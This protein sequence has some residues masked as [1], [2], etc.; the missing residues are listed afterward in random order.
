[1]SYRYLIVIILLF[2]LTACSVP[3]SIQGTPE[4]LRDTQANTSQASPVVE[5]TQPK[6]SRTT[7][8]KETPSYQNAVDKVSP[9]GSGSETQK[10]KDNKPLQ[11]NVESLP[12]PAFINEV[13]GN[14][15]GMSFEVEAS[16]QT[17][18][19][20][21]TLRVSEPQ[22]P[23]QLYQVA[24]Q[25]LDNYGVTGVKQGDILRFVP[26]TAAPEGG[27]PPILISGR[28]LPDVP[29]S[30]R[31]VFQIVPLR[32]VRN[33][34][35]AGW[36]R[37]LYP[38]KKLQISEDPERNAII[39]SG[40]PDLVRNAAEAVAFLDQPNMRGR[41]SLRIEPVF[42]SADELSTQLVSVLNT[43]GF[44]A[45]Q[46]AGLASVIVLPLKTVNAVIAFAA[47]AQVLEH[48]KRW[49]GTLDKP[50]HLPKKE[51][52]LFFYP[53][54]NTKA[55]N[56]SKVLTPLLQGVLGDTNL[57]TPN[58]TNPAVP[59][60]PAT[61]MNSATGRRM[62]VDTNRNAI[63]YQG[64]AESWARLLPILKEMDQPSKQTLIEVTIAEVTLSD[65]EQ[66][67]I[68]WL[69]KDLNLGGMTGTLASKLG[70]ATSSGL[71]YTFDSAGQT[72]AVLNAFAG[73]SQVNILS[74]PRVMVKSG[75]SASINV[76]TEVPIVTSQSTDPTTVRAGTTGVLQQIQYRRTGVILHV[77]PTVH[78]GNRIDLEV[79][80]EV[81]S[82]ESNSTSNISSPVILNR[83]VETKLSLSDGGS[84]LLG[85]L[86]SN[87][88]T[89]GNSGVPILKDLPLIGSIFRS[90]K[91]TRNR[92]E[93]IIVIVP[94]VIN[95]D[96]DAQSMTETFRQR[97]SLDKPFAPKLPEYLNFMKTK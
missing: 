82:A 8:F 38:S 87:S 46:G 43:Q 12:L 53:V 1:M 85:G 57:T 31:P 15:L 44:T 92:T 69:I 84:V 32:V 45:T 60:S 49:A 56:L 79:N 90:D 76:G 16:L 48:V 20:L 51:Q 58:L 93:L 40:M 66:L 54:Q 86:I 10:F 41:Y 95:T 22:T 81:S 23:A 88:T 37:Q 75:E 13:F 39:L 94:Y 34:H 91:Q 30:H 5:R 67:G 28:A 73:N 77:K 52:G 62:V 59:Q 4:P 2:E 70:V 6:L 97:L 19:D 74:S 64:D 65:Q 42:L 14:L 35:V 33:V 9:Q 21:V 24:R 50:G 36:L 72:R 18:K 7:G 89:Q 17:K 68:E 3:Y 71:T 78:A 47:D 27:E 29:V 26:T 83:S 61:P 55:E 96:Q 80:Q 11:V 63:L 25:I